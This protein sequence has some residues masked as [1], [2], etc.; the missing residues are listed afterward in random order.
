M[1]LPAAATAASNEASTSE[2]AVPRPAHPRSHRRKDGQ[3]PRPP[4][5]WI[6]YR[7]ARSQELRALPEYARV[8]QSEICESASTACPAIAKKELCADYSCALVARTNVTAKI[9]ARLWRDEDPA[10]RRSYELEAQELKRAHRE[11]YPG[12]RGSSRT[13]LQTH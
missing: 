9:I 3:P 2:S 11:Q 12:A 10:V 5:A 6:C 4:N 1:D 8:A 7:A 13:G